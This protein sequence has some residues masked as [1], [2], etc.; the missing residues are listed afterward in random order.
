MPRKKKNFNPLTARKGIRRLTIRER[1]DTIRQLLF[2]KNMSRYPINKD[3]R[4]F[5]EFELNEIIVF[6]ATVLSGNYQSGARRARGSGAPIQP[7]IGGSSEFDLS[8]S[9]SGNEEDGSGHLEGDIDID[10]VL[11][12]LDSE[13]HGGGPGDDEE[14][15]EI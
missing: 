4:A 12:D 6:L 1:R 2:G 13:I 8:L 9:R 11:R 15:D 3:G 5:N 14:D 7:A 10:Q